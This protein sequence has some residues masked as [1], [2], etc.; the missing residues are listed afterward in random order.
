MRREVQ[1]IIGILSGIE[2]FPPSRIPCA[3][4]SRGSETDLLAAIRQVRIVRSRAVA[5]LRYQSHPFPLPTKACVGNLRS[6]APWPG[7]V[8]GVDDCK[9]HGFRMCFVDQRRRW[10]SSCCHS[11][12]K[13]TLGVEALR[14]SQHVPGLLN[15]L[16]LRLISLWLATCNIGVS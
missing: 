13:V 15:L 11:T 4:F 9:F 3:A 1:E 7:C 6:A 16:L 2:L 14:C 5:I 8:R 10:F 12:S